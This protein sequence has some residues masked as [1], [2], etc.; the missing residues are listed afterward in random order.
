MKGSQK[1]KKIVLTIT[2]ALTALVATT[3]SAQQFV[4][5]SSDA[6]GYQAPRYL[7]FVPTRYEG[8]EAVGTCVSSVQHLVATGQ[9]QAYLACLQ[10]Y[11]ANS[12]GKVFDLRRSADVAAYNASLLPSKPVG[13]FLEPMNAGQ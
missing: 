8:D 13:S 4:H 2:A 11:V 6:V 3:A 1:I 10:G 12:H 7:V 9:L 5:R